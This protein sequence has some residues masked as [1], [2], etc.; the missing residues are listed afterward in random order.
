MNL[1]IEYSE[2]VVVV[3]CDKM[4]QSNPGDSVFQV[5]REISMGYEFSLDIGRQCYYKML[6]NA[7]SNLNLRRRDILLVVCSS[8]CYRD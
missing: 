7:G 6:Q 2:L 3:G 8:S 5:T 4:P 1:R